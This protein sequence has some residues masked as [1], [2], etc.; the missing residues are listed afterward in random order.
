MTRIDGRPLSGGDAAGIIAPAGIEGPA[1]LVTKNFDAIY[2]YN[3]AESYGLA[4]AVLSDRL[5]G[6]AGI[7]TAWPTDDPP[8]SRAERRQL[9]V[10]L[11]ARGYDVGEPD[12]RVGFQ[13]PR[14]DQGCRAP[15]RHD[16]DRTT[17]R[18]GAAGPA[19]RT[20]QPATC[21][22]RAA[23]RPKPIAVSARAA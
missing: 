12:G 21:R 11:A 6:K 3:A 2:S 22:S 16:A 17:G 20:A 15:A 13:D 1:F 7:R 8:L 10:A 23:P 5:R 4:I 14:R 19:L 9:Q 18:Q